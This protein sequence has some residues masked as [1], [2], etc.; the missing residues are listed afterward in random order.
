MY[1]NGKM[2]SVETVPRMEGTGGE[3]EWCGGDEFKY[4]IFDILLEL[5]HMPHCT[6]TPTQ[7]NNNKRKK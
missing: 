2:I 5:L 1:V 3:G 6:P 4:N 7:H